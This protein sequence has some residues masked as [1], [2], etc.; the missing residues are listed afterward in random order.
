[1]DDLNS[2]SRARVT[3]GGY[4]TRVSQRTPWQGTRFALHRAVSRSPGATQLTG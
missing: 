4:L 3:Y 2:R 1:M